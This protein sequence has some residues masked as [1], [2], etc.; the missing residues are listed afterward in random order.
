MTSDFG[1]M[2]VSR[3]TG[4]FCGTFFYCPKSVAQSNILAKK[5]LF[6]QPKRTRAVICGLDNQDREDKTGV[7]SFI[8]RTA[9]A[10]TPTALSPQPGSEAPNYGYL[11][12]SH[13]ALFRAKAP[14]PKIPR[15]NR[16]YRRYPLDAQRL[17]GGAIMLRQKMSS[18]SRPRA[19]SLAL[20]AINCLLT[21]NPSAGTFDRDELSQT[22][23]VLWELQSLCRKSPEG[24]AI[25]TARTALGKLERRIDGFPERRAIKP[26]KLQ[27]TAALL[28]PLLAQ[29]EVEE[30]AYWQEFAAQ[31]G[32]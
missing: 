19:L 15:T 24:K 22:F 11:I 1:K 28:R 29:L 2:I 8:A 20:D 9:G 26:E 18:I 14:C 17:D 21:G 23:D 27:E 16:I 30:E 32:G 7:L 13:K 12:F 4:D 6:Y 25:V 31:G 10:L 3:F 5:R